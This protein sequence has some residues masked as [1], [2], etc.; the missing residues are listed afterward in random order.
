M[1]TQFWMHASTSPAPEQ[2]LRQSL[3]PVQAS[4]LSQASI[5]AAHGPAVAHATHALH[6]DELTSATVPSSQSSPAPPEPP[7]PPTPPP[8]PPVPTTETPV[9]PV[10]QRRRDV[11]SQNL[12]T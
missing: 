5:S 4:E 7:P 9:H 8:T 2:S 11:D 6:S 12:G 1:S 10:E 3:K